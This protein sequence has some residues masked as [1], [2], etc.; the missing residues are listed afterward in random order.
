MAHRQFTDVNGVAWDVYD[1]V[2]LPGFGRPGEPQVAPN[3]EVFR[4]VRTWLV[5]ES[6]DEKRRLAYIPDNWESAPAQELERLLITAAPVR[7]GS[8]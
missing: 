8:T 1:V 5:F 2:A 7:K 4:A 6:A 3:S